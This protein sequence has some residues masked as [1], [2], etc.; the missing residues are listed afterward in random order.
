MILLFDGECNLCNS[1]VTYIIH[2]DSQN[3]FQ[4][5]SLQSN[6]GESF[7]KQFNL[8]TDMKTVVLIDGEIC[9]TK[10][11]AALYVC[12]NLKMPWPLLY[13]LIIIPTLLRDAIYDFVSRNRYKWFGK[14]KSCSVPTPEIKEKFIE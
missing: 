11:T 3:K 13:G 1:T 6:T 12:K 5:A 14:Q 8:S 10:S 9:Y 4:F 2:R 7:I